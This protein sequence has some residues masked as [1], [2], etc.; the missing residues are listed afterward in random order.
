M[1]KDKGGRKY[2]FF[3]LFGVFLKKTIFGKKGVAKKDAFGGPKARPAVALLMWF[4]KTHVFS[5]IFISFPREVKKLK[6]QRLIFD[7]TV[8]TPFCAQ[9]VPPPCFEIYTFSTHFS[10]K[11]K[12][13]KKLKKS[14]I[15]KQ[16]SM[17]PTGHQPKATMPNSFIS[18]G[19]Y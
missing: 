18:N 6:T 1:L 3:S 12:N 19:K 11:R 14:Q 8:P 16:Q 17:G 7:R 5:Q 15:P 13:T 9:R 2:T 4:F 10:K